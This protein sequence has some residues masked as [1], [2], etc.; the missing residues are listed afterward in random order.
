[1]NEEFQCL[2]PKILKENYEINK[3]LYEYDL[4]QKPPAH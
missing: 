1:M 3:A 4:K 2:F